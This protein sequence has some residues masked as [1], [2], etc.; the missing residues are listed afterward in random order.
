MASVL[1]LLVMRNLDTMSIFVH[2]IKKKTFVVIYFC[3]VQLFLKPVCIDRG[4]ITDSQTKQKISFYSF[5]IVFLQSSPNRE[6]AKFS[7]CLYTVVRL[8]LSMLPLYCGYSP[9]PATL[10]KSKILDL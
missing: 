5:P 8:K 2:K 9:Q 6:L 4:L 7:D 10:W 1:F 3:H